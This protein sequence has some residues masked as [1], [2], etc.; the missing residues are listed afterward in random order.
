MPLT[1]THDERLE[2][3]CRECEI[4]ALRWVARWRCPLR[5]YPCMTPQLCDMFA[6]MFTPRRLPT[7]RELDSDVIE[8]YMGPRGVIEL[9]RRYSEPY[10]VQMDRESHRDLLENSIGALV[11]LRP[12]VTG[13]TGYH[14]DA[15]Q[16]FKEHWHYG[17]P[18]GTKDKRTGPGWYQLPDPPQG[19][20]SWRAAVLERKRREI[21]RESLRMTENG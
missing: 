18:Y 2:N 5:H 9:E 16:W 14:R 12:E 1:C 11:E 4:Y 7:A 10:D 19:V 15:V 21:E 8:K 6:P 17:G 20:P 3:Y 13:D